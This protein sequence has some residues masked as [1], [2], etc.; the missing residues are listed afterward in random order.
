MELNRKRKRED[1]DPVLRMIQKAIEKAIGQKP[2]P[3]VLEP[4][5]AWL[6]AQIKEQGSSSSSSD[7]SS[8]SSSLASTLSVND[9]DSDVEGIEAAVACTQPRRKVHLP[10]EK[11][12]EQEEPKPEKQG[13]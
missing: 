9:D 5:M 11:K 7:S 6:I 8:S 2:P 13:P 1:E 3:A 10:Y 12:E 4:L